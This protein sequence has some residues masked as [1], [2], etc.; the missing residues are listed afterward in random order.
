M[1]GSQIPDLV[2]EVALRWQ[3]LSELRH[4]ETNDRAQRANGTQREQYGQDHRWDT[5]H[6]PLAKAPDPTRVI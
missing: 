5:P 1:A 2:A 4:L 3:I 6:A